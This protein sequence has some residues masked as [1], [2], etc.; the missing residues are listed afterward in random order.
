M[1]AKATVAKKYAAEPLRLPADQGGANGRQGPVRA[2]S[3][4][5]VVPSSVPIPPLHRHTWPLNDA[6]QIRDRV[7][8]HVERRVGA[9]SPSSQELGNL[10][11]NGDGKLTSEEWNKVT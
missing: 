3:C 2:W 6:I 1:E 8:S 9:H 4:C 10:D 5:C 7:S 11:A